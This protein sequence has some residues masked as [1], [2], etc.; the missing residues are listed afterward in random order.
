MLNRYQHFLEKAN[1]LNEVRILASVDN[2]HI[3]SY[4]EAFYDDTSSSSRRQVVFVNDNVTFSSIF[5]SK[6]ERWYRIMNLL[7]PDLRFL[8]IVNSISLRKT[9]VLLSEL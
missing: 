3:V 5:S 8:L 6:G 2:P 1:A 7:E 4:K 9:V